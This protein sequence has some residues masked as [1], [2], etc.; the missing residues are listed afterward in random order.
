MP[1]HNHLYILALAA[2][3]AGTFLFPSRGDASDVQIFPP[4]TVA[5]LVCPQGDTLALTWDGTHNVECSNIP[6]C[7]AALGQGLNFDGSNFTC[8]TPCVP[9][10]TTIDSGACPSGETGS[11]VSQ[12]AM[13]TCDGSPPIPTG[14]PAV[15]TCT[16]TVEV[17]FTIVMACNVGQVVYGEY[18]S[19]GNFNTE[20]CSQASSHCAYY[21]CTASGL[22]AQ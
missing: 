6:T 16:A 14:A 18:D 4:Q 13:T 19:T 3:V 15:N 21:T 10:P 9:Q 11:P 17:P 8:V 5:G 20:V 2:A 22:V 12:P 7:N 1:G